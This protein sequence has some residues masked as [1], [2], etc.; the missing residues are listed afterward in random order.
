MPYKDK[1]EEK[2]HRRKYYLENK[3]KILKNHKEYWERTKEE[4]H[5]Q[6]NKYY[7]NNK[8]NVKNY[9]IGYRAKN[10]DLILAKKK[11]YRESHRPQRNAHER[12]RRQKD[13]NY[14]LKTLMSSR[15]R[16]QIGCLKANKKTIDLLNY[17]SQDLIKHLESQFCLGMSWS[18]YKTYWVIDHI[19]PQAWFDYEKSPLI[20]IREANQLSNLQPL[21]VWINNIKKDKCELKLSDIRD[22]FELMPEDIRKI[23]K[24]KY[25]VN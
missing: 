10:R 8:E 6:Q 17:T 24:E 18:N 21:P 19:K 4:R 7:L 23:M 16:K 12:E 5:K 2:K 13:L 25:G 1:E 20:S 14:R 11:A 22:T 9:G 3:D 15:I